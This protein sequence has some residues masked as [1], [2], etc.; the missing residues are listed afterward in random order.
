M[1]DIYHLPKSDH[2]SWH[3]K[4]RSKG[5]RV[6]DEVSFQ[7]PYSDMAILSQ[8]QIQLPA[9]GLDNDQTALPR[10]GQYCQMPALCPHPPPPPLLGFTLI[11]ALISRLYNLIIT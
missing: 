6:A 2:P 9:P 7:S 1:T 4:R 3:R 10:E 5:P 11:R 8:A